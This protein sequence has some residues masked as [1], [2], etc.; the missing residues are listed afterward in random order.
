MKKFVKGIRAGSLKAGPTN[1]NKL[2]Y[3]SLASSCASTL[4]VTLDLATKARGRKE[5]SSFI[6]LRQKHAAASL[7]KFIKPVGI[8]FCYV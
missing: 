3:L 1:C 2:L 6:I 5:D 4:P 8:F 7:I